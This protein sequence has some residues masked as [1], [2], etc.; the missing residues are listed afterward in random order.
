MG[1]AYVS[2]RQHT[3]AYVSI[4]QHM[5]AYVSI[6]QHTS[7]YVSIRQHTSA[8]VSIRQHPSAYVSIRQHIH[9]HTHKTPSASLRTG[10]EGVCVCG[11]VEQVLTRRIDRRTQSPS[12]LA[13]PPSPECDTPPPTPLGAAD[14]CCKCGS[15]AA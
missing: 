3:S 8:Y 13:P 1:V 7:A 11:C 14:H 15:I 4:R 9:T 10:D 2:I 5:S 6:R 12:A